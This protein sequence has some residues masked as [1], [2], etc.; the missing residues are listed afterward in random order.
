MLLCCWSLAHLVAFADTTLVHYYRGGPKTKLSTAVSAAPGGGTA[1]ADHGSVSCAE[2][3]IRALHQS[4]AAPPSASPLRTL[5]HRLVQTRR[6][7]AVSA[8][9]P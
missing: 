6:E 5:S 9:I 1:H 8:Q 2:M 3:A 4:S 7:V